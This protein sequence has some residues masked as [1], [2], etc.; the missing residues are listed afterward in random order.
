MFP[1]RV[2]RHQLPDGR[3]TESYTALAVGLVLVSWL[4]GSDHRALPQ[5]L[6]GLRANRKLF[7]SRR[8]LLRNRATLQA[9]FV[10]A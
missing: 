8:P 9:C 7:H 2:Y 10:C 6:G 3:L 4:V 5:I 1:E